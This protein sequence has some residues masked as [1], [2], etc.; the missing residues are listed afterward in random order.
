[1]TPH[2]RW[3]QLQSQS[4]TS[5][6]N[7]VKI[8]THTDLAKQKELLEAKYKK[9]MEELQAKQQNRMEAWRQERQKR[10]EDERKRIAEEATRLDE[11]KEKI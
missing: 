5:T 10:E 2:K 1:L 9:E 3:G 6:T 7:V 8:P 4:T 11:K